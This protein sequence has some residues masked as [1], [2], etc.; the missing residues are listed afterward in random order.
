[1]A[2]KNREPIYPYLF[3][4]VVFNKNDVL[5]IDDNPTFN[6]FEK[7]CE[8]ISLKDLAQYNQEKVSYGR[9]V[10]SK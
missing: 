7:D 6:S 3:A 10:Y 4:K 1:M 8:Y 9:Y 2:T 5:M